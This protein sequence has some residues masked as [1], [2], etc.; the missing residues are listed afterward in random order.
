V[1][2]HRRAIEPIHL[3]H[4]DDGGRFDELA[5]LNGRRRDDAAALAVDGDEFQQAG[6]RQNDLG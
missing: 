2:E 3:L 5:L 4:L 1:A 6:F